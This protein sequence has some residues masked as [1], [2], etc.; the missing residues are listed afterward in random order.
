MLPPVVHIHIAKAAHQQLQLIFIKNFN[1]INRKQF[2]E[3]LKEKKSHPKIYFSLKE[4]NFTE[5]TARKKH[6]FC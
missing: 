2:C 4:T 6:I 5:K 1:Q 3:S